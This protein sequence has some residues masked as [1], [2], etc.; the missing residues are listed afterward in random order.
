[1][2]SVMPGSIVAVDIGGTKV[3]TAIV[4]FDGE[5]PQVGPIS[6]APTNARLGGPAVLDRVVG[7]VAEM[8]DRAQGP[9]CGIGVSSAG[10]ID[11]VSGDVTF[12]NDLMPGWGGTRLGRELASRFGLPVRVMG[13]VHAHALGEARHGAGRGLAS[14][15][16]VAVGT[17]IGGAFVDH[18]S[19]MLGAHDVAGHV[20]HVS[21]LDAVGVPCSC[22]A[23]GHLESV[24]SG[25]GII[26]EFLRLGGSPT[27]PDGSAID[28]AQIDRLAASG[29]EA[30][31][32]AERRAG[33]ALGGVLGSLCNV[34]DPACVILSGS[35]VQ[36]GASWS[37]ALAEGFS[38]Q[39]MT[40]VARTPV[41][42][43]SLGG[44]APLIGAADN[45]LRP[46]YRELASLS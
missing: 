4:A 23:V 24:A 28:G 32:S 18:G 6:K 36:C 5:V 30:A 38:S 39:A 26:E 34:L 15:L 46:C 11:P 20:G 42:H 14:C 16:V 7:L 25:P 8:I 2:A 27:S 29:D 9:V 17:G 22:G 13:D 43:G 19:V 21:C 45:L 44:E 10:V 41:V 31:I 40:P 1:M 37:D 35:V 33:H 3:A 12:A